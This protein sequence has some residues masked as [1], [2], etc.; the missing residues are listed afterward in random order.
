MDFNHRSLLSRFFV[1]TIDEYF[2]ADGKAKRVKGVAPEG[3]R[4][5]QRFLPL[6]G[7]IIV[8]E[9]TVGAIAVIF[10][11]LAL[12]DGLGQILRLRFREC[13]RK[14]FKKIISLGLREG[15]RRTHNR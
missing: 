6:N 10:G 5:L 12:V 11:A 14:Y 1:L 3:G 7:I 4:F 15:S 8:L 9:I 13:P 2:F